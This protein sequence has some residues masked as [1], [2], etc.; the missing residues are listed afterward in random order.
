MKINTEV[1]FKGH[2]VNITEMEKA[3]KENVKALG[4][5]ISTIESLDIYYSP[6]TSAVYYVA[7]TNDGSVI[8]NDEALAF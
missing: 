7:T 6:E 5:K 8:S 3:V 2:N 1:Q 4:V